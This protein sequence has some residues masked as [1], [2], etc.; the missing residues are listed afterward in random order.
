[1]SFAVLI[2]PLLVL[3]VTAVSW[4]MWKKAELRSD[5]FLLAKDDLKDLS[6]GDVKQRWIL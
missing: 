1:M 5:K 6:I 3:A 2:P 4:R